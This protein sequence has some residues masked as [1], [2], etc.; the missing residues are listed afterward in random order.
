MVVLGKKLLGKPR[1]EE[2]AKAMLLNLS[3]K[4]HKVITSVAIISPKGRVLFHD[5]AWVKFRNIDEGEIDEYIKTGEP[6]DKAG[7]YAV[8]GYG[9]KFVEKIRGDFYTV[10]G[11]PVVKTDLFLRRLLD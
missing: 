2:H 1:D 3:G 5:T 9:A 8:Q 6:M 4:W 11:L 7:A 10:M